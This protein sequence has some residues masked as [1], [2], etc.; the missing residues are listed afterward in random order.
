[1]RGR[2]LISRGSAAVWTVVIVIVLGLALLL[3]I[4][5]TVDMLPTPSDPPPDPPKPATQP[6]TAPTS[7]PAEP[8][9]MRSWKDLLAERFPDAESL[10]PLAEP[11]DLTDAAQIILDRPVYLCPRG[12]LWITHPDADPIDL[13]LTRAR[14]ETVHLVRERIVYVHWQQERGRWRAI[15]I[16]Q[17]EDGY[18]TLD[19]RRSR[20][21]SRENAPDFV[22]A[23]RLGDAAIVPVRGGLISLRFTPALQTE[24]ARFDDS[25][26]NRIPHLLHDGS[27]LV[28]F[29]P[30]TA[31]QPGSTQVLR[32]ES[33]DL[34]PAPPA[35]PWPARVAHVIP[36]VDGSAR[37]ICFDDDNQLAIRSI[38]IRTRPIDRATITKLVE[39]LSDPAAQRRE[40]AMT[41]L[42]RFGNASWPILEELLPDQLPEGQA[43]LR[44]LL[45]E[46]EEPSILGYL[47]REGL[48][49]IERQL[50]DNTALLFAPRGWV[51]KDFDAPDGLE[52]IENNWLLL[53]QVGASPV[54][55]GWRALELLEAGAILDGIGGDLLL[56]TPRGF[57]QLA[58][59]G[60][61]PLLAPDDRP[62][63]EFVGIDTSRRWVL[64]SSHRPG[65]TLLID[66]SLPPI[67]PALPS[68][69]V[70]MGPIER[71]G[72]TT[73]GWPIV[74]AGDPW[75]LKET[76]WAVVQPN[77][78]LPADAAGPGAVSLLPD[79]IVLVSPD[80]TQRPFPW[81]TDL[82]PNDRAT[83]AAVDNRTILLAIAPNTI[84]RLRLDPT[85][86]TLKLIATH[87]LD[88]GND[89]PEAMWT[90]PAGR[91]ILALPGNRLVVTFPKGIIPRPIRNLMPAR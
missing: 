19:E 35:E 20:V 73:E 33:A 22:S 14:D 65:Q 29:I 3:G 13:V 72:R 59:A 81:P 43:R 79:R 70:D 49:T 21:A 24:S 56:L 84:H 46:R 62:F 36:L 91:V 1:M 11:A 38:L 54:P 82:A 42:A 89:L 17:R 57:V 90:D 74:Q 60:I 86:S 68:W 88:L 7:A 16:E 61:A 39:Q 10:D 71:L 31:T 48:L 27:G 2:R 18:Y 28:A 83:A 58:G 23:L 75:A 8:K 69:L 80:G 32:F 45:G 85:T 77:E 5:L 12:H 9:V 66:P 25:A 37:V 87:E 30:W 78:V 6:A 67:E 53:P 15:P 47:P 4:V 44:L 52:D 50:R 26:G 51:R 40:Q 55:A 64:R 76:G 41:E 34:I 63:D